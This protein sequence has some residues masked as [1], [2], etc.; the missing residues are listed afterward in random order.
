[1]RTIFN[2][3]INGIPT[4]GVAYDCGTVSQCACYDNLCGSK[5]KGCKLFP[6]IAKGIKD[7][8][9][10]RIIIIDS[11]KQQFYSKEEWD[12]KMQSYPVR[13][14]A[15]GFTEHGADCDIKEAHL[16]VTNFYATSSKLPRDIIS[17]IVNELSVEPKS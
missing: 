8:T 13:Y 10:K 5:N 16:R 3:F 7:A 1:M 4:D 15:L 12:E 6:K 2:L 9:G 14:Q 17:K 11:G